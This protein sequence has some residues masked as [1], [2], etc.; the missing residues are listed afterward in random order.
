MKPIRIAASIFA[1]LCFAPLGAQESKIYRATDN[2][3]VRAAPTTTSPKIG[4]LRSGKEVEVTGSAAGG[5]WHRVRLQNGQTGFV[6]A[7]LLEEA[8]DKSLTPDS[9]SLKGGPSEAPED[10]YAYIVWPRDGEVI[11]GGEFV[12]LF[13]LHGMGTAPAGVAKLHT[14]HHHLLINAELPPLDE[15]IPADDQHFHFGRGQTEH[16]LVLPQGEHTL[17][18]LLGDGDHIPH[19]PPVMSERITIRVP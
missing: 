7:K 13:G 12:V 2:S 16:R 5:N 17:Q 3:N 15:P 9:P 4:Y 1:L 18:L 6:F 10:A 19:T 14:G 8:G 11:P